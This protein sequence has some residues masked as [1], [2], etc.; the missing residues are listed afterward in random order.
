MTLSVLTRDEQ[1]RLEEPA[2]IEWYEEQDA[3]RILHD[4][5]MWHTMI[6]PSVVLGRA[7]VTLTTLRLDPHAMD[8]PIR[9]TSRVQASDIQVVDND[10]EFE[11][12]EEV[13]QPATHQ[14]VFAETPQL[15]AP[16]VPTLH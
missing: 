5:T 8:H 7:S 14:L 3:A 16:I 9:Q 1:E 4:E 10:D 15:L 11:D 6:G 13:P 2:E 12:T